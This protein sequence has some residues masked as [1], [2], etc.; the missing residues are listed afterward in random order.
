MAIWVMERLS[1]KRKWEAFKSFSSKKEALRNSN[2][3]NKN[4]SR[5]L[6]LQ[7]IKYR[8]RKAKNE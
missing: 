7:G 8:I 6:S 1:N 2:D 4:I 5:E 3:A